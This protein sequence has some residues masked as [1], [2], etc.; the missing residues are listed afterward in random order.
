LRHHQQ[1]AIDRAEREVHLLII[2]G[3]NAHPQHSIGQVIGIR[4]GIVAADAQQD[5]ETAA[6]S[7]DNPALDLNLGVAD[8][9]QNYAHVCIL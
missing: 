5:H 4:L 6:D 8:A 1:F 2:I 7:G 3:K 9:L